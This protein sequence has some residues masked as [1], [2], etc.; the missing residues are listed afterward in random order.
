MDGKA[1]MST[2][3]QRLNKSWYKHW[4]GILIVIPA[5]P[6]F[7]LWYVWVEVER[8][9][10]FRLGAVTVLLALYAGGIMSLVYALPNSSPTKPLV[11][12]TSIATSQNTNSAS[13][14]PPKSTIT[15]KT[16]AQNTNTT[17]ATA[18]SQV[19]TP[20]PPSTT[21]PI[22]A[23]PPKT[24]LQQ[25]P[26]TYPV[27]WA[28]APADT[29]IDT[30]GMDNRES[31]SY[32]AWKVNEAFGNMP[33]WGIGST[34]DAK[35]WPADAQAAGIP[36]GTTPKVHSVAINPA[37][38]HGAGSSGFSTWV[39]AVNGD[40]ITISFYNLGNAYDYSVTTE[41]AAY[42]ETYIYFGGQ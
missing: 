1:K 23:S 16:S 14:T 9:K 13:A 29:I 7:A 39:E 8:S 25:Y 15:T 17:K 34:G 18:T 37:N 33:T 24:L 32:T 38:T 28:D 22:V 26:D 21:Q 31:T 27:K 12:A 5:L 40:Q 6:L 36:T 4:W 3:T 41:S 10:I 42:F 35:D 19:T 30:W 11:T 2:S 20:T